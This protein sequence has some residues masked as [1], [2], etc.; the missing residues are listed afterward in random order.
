M[1][2]GLFVREV[3]ERR[4]G[5][6]ESAPEENDE[7]RKNE[8]DPDALLFRRSERLVRDD[9]QRHANRSAE[10]QRTDEVQMKRV[11]E[12][13]DSSDHGA[14]ADHQL[15]GAEV[16]GFFFRTLDFRRV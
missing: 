2:F 8:D 4:A 11:V 16:W 14:D 13:R 6:F 1:S 5:L 15:V 10:D 7:E 9:E 12:H 3:S